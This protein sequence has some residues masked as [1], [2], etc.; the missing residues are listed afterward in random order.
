MIL[1]AFEN[2]RV[3]SYTNMILRAFE[4]GRAAASA[5][6]LSTEGRE[7]ASTR[8][9][10]HHLASMDPNRRQLLC[11]IW[12]LWTLTDDNYYVPFGVYGP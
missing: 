10:V 9:I 6:T 1:R 7:H 5:S 11:T 4:N 2:G 8:I 3:Y 12:C